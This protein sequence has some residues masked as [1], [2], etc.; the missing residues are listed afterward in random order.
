MPPYPNPHA[1]TQAH[2]HAGTHTHTPPTRPRRRAVS[3]T[4]GCAS[5]S[6]TS[7]RKALSTCRRGGGRQAHA[8]TRT[9]AP[10]HDQPLRGGS[11]PAHVPNHTHTGTRVWHAGGRRGG[12]EGA[13]AHSRRWRCA[14]SYAMRLLAVAGRGDT[15][16]RTPTS[17]GAARAAGRAAVGLADCPLRLA[18]RAV[19]RLLRGWVEPGVGARDGNL[20]YAADPP[21]LLFRRQLMPTSLL[22]LGGHVGVRWLS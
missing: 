16:P 12:G 14:G 20:A 17:R 18:S 5:T 9:R 2:R 15:W 7:S 22:L 13:L 19:A 1:G 8:R 21:S 3:L 10:P 11:A 6:S 4:C